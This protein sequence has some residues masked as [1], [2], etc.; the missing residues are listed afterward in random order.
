MTVYFKT[1]KINQVEI[2]YREAGNTEKPVIV[3]L[4]GFPATSFMFRDLINDL[5]EKYRVIAPDYPGFGQ[6][7]ALPPDEF[8]YTFEN[9]SICME[10]FII[11]LGIKKLSLYMH[12]FGGPIGFRIAKRRSDLIQ[13]L[14]I[15]NANAYLNGIG[16]ALKPLVAYVQNQTHETEKGARSFL[17]SDATN[18]QYNHGVSDTTKVS[19][20][21]LVINQYY[22]TRPGNDEI[23]LALF[24]DY[25]SNLEKYDEWHDYFQK[26][27][28]PTL[29]LWGKNDELF[30]PQGAKA[31][32]KHLP[33]AK[34]YFINS[35]HF[36]LEDY[37][38]YAA[39]LID[40]F[41]TNIIGEF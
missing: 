25:G 26:K 36:I 29:V 17:A 38:E 33:D 4:H 2:F 34:I 31:Y 13:S 21:N 15:Q 27:Q 32:R 28:P 20:D 24:R 3:L 11:A 18:W 40:K 41:M 19:P 37:H 16:E 30:I 7:T 9:L 12:A 6:S 1:I 22:L 23:Q 5:S 39:Q 14:I 8:N 35:G 10:E